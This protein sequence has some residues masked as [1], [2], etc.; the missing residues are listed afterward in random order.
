MMAYRGTPHGTH[1]F[2]P[3]YLLYGREMVLPTSQDL[4]VKLTAEVKET[5]FEHRL[6]KF[7]TTLQSAYKVV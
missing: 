6:E 2:S 7:K 1:G 4:K 3:F 5:D